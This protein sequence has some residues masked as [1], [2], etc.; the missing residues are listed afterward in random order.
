MRNKHLTQEERYQIHALRRQGV[1]F[2]RIGAEL[3]RHRSSIAR[4]FKRNASPHGYT[5]AKAHTMARTRQTDRRNARQTSAAQW[6]RV[7]AYLRLF[8]SPEQ[9]AGRLRLEGAFAISHETIYQHI[10]QDKRRGGDLI[11]YLR[12]QKV[13]R[14]RYGSGQERRGVLRDRVCIDQRPPI[15][16][17]KSRI[18]DWE[19]DTVIG[20]GHQGALVTLVE[21]KSRYT[22][23]SRVASRHSEGV[24][25][26]VI[27]LL[28]PYQHLCHTVTFDNGKEFAEHAFIGQCLDAD[29]YFA[30]PYHSWERGL[31]ENTNG[32]LRQRFPKSSNFLK[33]SDE[34]VQE[35]VYQLNHRP[36][37]CLGFRTPH[38]VFH[39]IEMKP[40]TL[41]FGAFCN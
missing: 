27:R 38:E 37:K 10:Y 36:R 15:V 16:A 3:N 26:A 11:G 24:T 25:Q 33:V 20:K 30:H 14:K 17:R 40:L 31:N 19:G 12:C 41:A 39:A 13:R 21:R 35:A 18:G 22:L 5:P 2:A 4:E 23:S 7:E 8:L 1:S 28:R 34:D 9:V 32:L 29:I 6:L